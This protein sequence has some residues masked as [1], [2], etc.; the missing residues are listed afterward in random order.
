[1]TTLRRS[2]NEEDGR[3][4]RDDRERHCHQERNKCQEARNFQIESE[5]PGQPCAYSTQDRP[6][7]IAIQSTC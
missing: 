1:M 6:I 3:Q 7:G 2:W 4:V 5:V